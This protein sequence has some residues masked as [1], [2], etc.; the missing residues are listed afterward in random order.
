MG[1]AYVTAWM[2][3]RS[4]IADELYKKLSRQHLIYNTI[5]YNST[6]EHIITFTTNH[7]LQWSW[8]EG[9]NSHIHGPSG[10]T[11]W[12]CRTSGNQYTLNCIWNCLLCLAFA[13]VLPS[14]LQIIP[15]P[16]FSVKTF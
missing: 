2:V 13:L 3:M 7:S 14:Q 15:P 4:N 9:T 5:D 11:E 1:I 12:V 16:G 10:R 8:K 6:L